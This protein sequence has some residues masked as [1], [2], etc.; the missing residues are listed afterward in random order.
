M[1]EDFPRA[2]F[3]WQKSGKIFVKT[4]DKCEFWGIISPACNS[5]HN[6][7]ELCKG[8]TR[9]SE[10]LC[11]G[12]IPSSAAKKKT[13]TQSGVRFL[14]CLQSARIEPTKCR[15]HFSGF[16]LVETT[17]STILAQNRGSIPKILRKQ[18]LRQAPS[19]RK[20]EVQIPDG[21]AQT[22]FRGR[23]GRRPL[24]R[25]FWLVRKRLDF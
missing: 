10:S 17:T 15:R 25:G 11:L 22:C 6:F 9:V 5:E 14:F 7:A 13:D 2:P 21:F 23:R 12:S 20:T 8:S 3:L 4:L 1:P 18:K 19:R 16:A 24:R